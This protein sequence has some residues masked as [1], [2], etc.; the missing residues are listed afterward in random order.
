MPPVKHFGKG[1]CA[2]GL[3]AYKGKGCT[4]NRTGTYVFLGA[5]AAAPLL[6]AAGPAI[7]G[8]AIKASAGVGAGLRR[9]APATGRGVTHAAGEAYRARAEEGF[10]D[11]ST[12]TG[13]AEPMDTGEGKP[14][15]VCS[16]AL[17]GGGLLLALFLLKR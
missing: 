17:I 4:G 14:C 12:Q 11:P 9:L 15:S 7:G 5:V 6:V 3:V 16:W 2:G 10:V 1:T 13:I 8:A